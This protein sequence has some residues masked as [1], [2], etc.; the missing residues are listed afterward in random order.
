M[1]LNNGRIVS[2]WGLIR[3]FLN[4]LR[5][6]E[7]INLS[8][9][10]D[11]LTLTE[12]DLLN[13]ANVNIN[14]GA[15]TDR[16]NYTG[17]GAGFVDSRYSNFEKLKITLDNNGNVLTMNSAS[18]WN[19]AKIS[20][21]SGQDVINLAASGTYDLT[22]VNWRSV[23]QVTVANASDN[24]AVKIDQ[25]LSIDR[26]NNGGSGG[27]V[28]KIVGVGSNAKLGFGNLTKED[29]ARSL[30]NGQNQL[31]K[32]DYGNDTLVYQGQTYE[33]ENIGALRFKNGH[34]VYLDSRNN[35][36][37]KVDSALPTFNGTEDITYR[38]N[39]SQQNTLKNKF[40]DFDG[41]N[42][43]VTNINVSGDTD[44]DWYDVRL[45]ANANG[46][47]D[48]SYTVS[49]GNGGT[50]TNNM[51]IDFAAVNDTPQ[52]TFISL[53][54]KNDTHYITYRIS[55]VEDGDKTLVEEISASLHSEWYWW[56]DYEITDQTVHKYY[57]D[58]DGAR[59]KEP[60]IKFLTFMNTWSRSDES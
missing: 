34:E 8:T 9:A 7:Q 43:S 26:F 42:I 15:G 38:F 49:D 29:F 23:E 5:N 24:V 11:T 32:N 55:D 2:Y 45:A 4:N 1:D 46:R 40:Y 25:N 31:T 41:D 6:F 60:A 51:R 56:G 30:Q 14:G 50:A 20:G 36:P 52:A 10:N 54:N 57:T 16:L 58:D 27:H 39:S 17:D 3:R 13:N 19:G 44:S 12:T 22:G 47:K 59:I 21:G 33:L 18:A 35:A 53:E 48:G 37:V 28:D